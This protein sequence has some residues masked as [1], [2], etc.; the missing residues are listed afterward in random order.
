VSTV[1]YATLQVIPS[2]KGAEAIINRELSGIMPGAG[3]RAGESLGGG[4]TSGFQRRM[5]ALPRIAGTAVKATGVALAAG[6]VGAGAWGLKIAAANEQAQISFETMLGSGQKARTFLGDLR[7]FAA[8]TPFEF[9]EL[10]TAAS[11]LISAGVEA[12]KVIP[13]MTT[14][15]DVTAGMGTGSDGIRRATV[16]LQQMQ[17][18][19]KITGE[20]LNQLRDAGIPVYDLL[21]AA[22]GRAKSEVTQLAAAGKLGKADLDALMQGLESGKG[23][24]RFAGLM[25][26]QS[27]SLTGLMSTMKDTFGQNLAVA[28][29]PVVDLAK[30]TLPSLTTA[31]EQVTGWFADGL[32]AAIDFGQEVAPL[33]RNLGRELVPILQDLADIAVKP[34]MHAA[35]EGLKGVLAVAAPT[36]RAIGDLTGFLA[37]HEVVVQAATAALIGWKTAETLAMASTLG[38]TAAQGAST[39]AVLAG[40]ISKGAATVTS[41]ALAAAAYLETLAVDG[42]AAAYA[43]LNISMAG[44]AAGGLAGVAIG[45]KLSTDSLARS[46]D[47]GTEAAERFI[48]G[49]NID[50]KNAESMRVGLVGI[51]TE[52]GKLGKEAGV[53]AWTKFGQRLNPFAD[54]KADEAVAAMKRLDEESK[55]YATGLTRIYKAASLLGTS[56]GVVTRWAD[57][58]DLDPATTKS[59]DLARAIGEARAAAQHGT[60][61]TDAL[62]TSYKV[63]ADETATATDKMQAWK[64]KLDLILRP[65]DTARADIAFKGALANMQETFTKNAWGLFDTNLAAGRENSS[66]LLDSLSAAKDLYDA[67]VTQGRT[68]EA[69]LYLEDARQKII[70]TGT[71]AG[72]A[73]TDVEGLL[74]Q[75]GLAPDTVRT[76]FV[77]NT[78]EEADKA[79]WLASLMKNLDGKTASMLVKI[80]V[81]W[82]EATW[83]Q[84]LLKGNEPWFYKPGAS[85]GPKNAKG[86]TANILTGSGSSNPVGGMLGGTKKS[87]A[88]VLP[89]QAPAPT[90][91]AGARRGG[92]T[93]RDV[94]V[95]STGAT[96][97]GVA[98]DLQWELR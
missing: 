46:A 63:L 67:Y 27:E 70:A 24:E 94:T 16:A 20:D 26:K 17:S 39:T 1:G 68:K 13:I 66:A 41:G 33:A 95:I 50:P 19:G 4:V 45:W 7:D 86:G 10:Q 23:L 29:Q 84:E 40:N 78:A 64:D 74:S 25:D 55:R 37:D 44:M 62:A 14:L 85:A 49:I 11:S 71:Q 38:F 18:A 89:G 72:F 93:V 51:N 82:S 87:K 75:F 80:G 59:T 69:A 48:K 88:V 28:M 6:V 92:S 97:S 53:S 36:A 58:L 2:L 61:T 47:H 56:S 73:A 60:P 79:K 76:E 22:T 34:A 15:G 42:L 35:A 52:M 91:S 57:K 9:P 21:A 3:T 98:R 65:A 54:N 83:F 77:T 96:A 30:D 81:D 5:A 32:Q 90:P 12:G 8:K 43:N 31:G